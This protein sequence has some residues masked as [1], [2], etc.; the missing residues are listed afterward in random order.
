MFIL[1]EAA[2]NP[3]FTLDEIDFFDT[4]LLV[5]GWIGD[6]MMRFSNIRMKKG[7]ISHLIY[8]SH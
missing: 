8:A 3:I 6:M 1:I 4:I 7:R 2:V 5:R